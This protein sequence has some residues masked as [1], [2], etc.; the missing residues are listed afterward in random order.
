VAEYFLV[1]KK[2][3][4]GGGGNAPFPVDSKYRQAASTG[5]PAR[6]QGTQGYL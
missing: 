4:I 5:Q 3:E 2:V 1:S 6:G